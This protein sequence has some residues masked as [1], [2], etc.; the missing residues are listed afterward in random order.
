MDISE[1]EIRT[2]GS[3]IAKDVKIDSALGKFSRL[4]GDMRVCFHGREVTF[5]DENF[6]DVYTFTSEIFCVLEQQIYDLK[7]PANIELRSGFDSL[8]GIEKLAPRH[9]AAFYKLASEKF[10]AVVPEWMKDMQKS[11]A[12][13]FYMAILSCL[14]TKNAIPSDFAMAFVRDLTPDKVSKYFDKTWV[15]FV[16]MFTL[17]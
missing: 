6:G 8:I 12:M 4:C 9:I 10:K 7:F 16:G 1:Y 14:Y 15:D 5:T 17:Q 13:P 3:I 2:L 11:N